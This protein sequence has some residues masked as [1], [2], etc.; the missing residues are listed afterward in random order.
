[1]N[2]SF[3]IIPWV[4]LY[5]F[6]DGKVYPCPALAGQKNMALGSNTDSV[7]SLWNSEVLTTMRAKMLKGIP[8]S[9][10][11]T[12]CNNCLNSCKKYF[13]N[14]LFEHAK[15]SIMSTGEDGRCNS[16][17]IAWNVIESNV[18]NL[19]C[20]YCTEDYSCK[21]GNCTIKTAFPD[22]HNFY[23]DNIQKVKEIWF[24]SGEP[25]I[26]E[27][28]Y[29]ILEELL[30]RG[31]SDIRIRFITNLM[32]TQYKSYKIYDLLSQFSNVI[33]FGSWDLDGERGEFIRF[34]SNSEKIKKTIRLINDK[35]IPF[36]LQSVMSILNICY[37]PEFHKRLIEESLVRVDNIRYYN[38]NS[39]EILRYSIL[40]NNRKEIVRD[41]LI[42]YSKW[43]MLNGEKDV[44]ANMELPSTTIKNIANCL[45]T[46]EGGHFGFSDDNNNR[47]YCECVKVVYKQLND[48]G[49]GSKLFK[50]VFYD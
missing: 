38:L 28:T 49:K 36:Y 5:Y 24:A 18:C 47:W 26:Q 32:F 35:K 3:C 31:M 46:G 2:K 13:G 15:T 29:Q 9:E 10:C 30:K 14:D 37:Y 21:H 7:D 1:M 4:H 43:L 39:P 11:D 25:V 44:F 20:I 33:V 19:K 27:S 41:K 42:E 50:E 8:I 12:A 45:M 48:A 34:N 23:L 6:T 16:N 17:F 40:P 22:S